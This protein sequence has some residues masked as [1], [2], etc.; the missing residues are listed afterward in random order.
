MQ[1]RTNERWLRPCDLC[2]SL[3][4]ERLEQEPH[5][6]YRCCDCSLIQRAEEHGNESAP[7]KLDSALFS[8]T[9]NQIIR[10]TDG[11]T[12]TAILIIGRPSDS[13]FPCIRNSPLHITLLVEP[14]ETEGLEGLSFKIGGMEQ[15]LFRPEQFDVILCA[16]GMDSLESAA[17]LFARARLWLAPE[18][19]LFVGGANWGSLTRR[20]WFGRW[21]SHH[22][23]GRIFADPQH[24]KEYG[25]RYGFDQLSGGTRS[26]INET[27]AIT[28]AV[29]S[30]SF[31]LRTVALPF[32]LVASL[33]GLGETWWS[34]LSKRGYAVRPVLRR[35]E[36]EP[37]RTAG[38]A[39]ATFGSSQREAVSSK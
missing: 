25:L 27:A 2:G 35:L 33:P 5:S 1:N 9:L 10:R 34:I 4:Y 11:L 28:F 14:D 12:D 24:L 39:A 26:H 21:R 38:L 23:G 17:S 19:L 29:P 15:N 18:G 22:K 20:L 31:L 8:T 3:N 32:W 13:V 7:Q 16:R 6:L 30:P 36:E 37:E